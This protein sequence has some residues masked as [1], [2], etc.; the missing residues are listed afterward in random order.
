MFTNV[1]PKQAAAEQ[2]AIDLEEA[3][4]KKA[5]MEAEVAELNAALKILQDKF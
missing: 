2:A 5:K 4:T 1:A 3:N